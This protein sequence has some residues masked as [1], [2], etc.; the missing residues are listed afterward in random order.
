[1]DARL[2]ELAGSPSGQP[3]ALGTLGSATRSI[4]GA[5]STADLRAV[6][7][8]VALGRSRKRRRRRHR[9]RTA[10]LLGAPTPRR[11]T[12]DA[13]V[14]ARWDRAPPGA[15]PRIRSPADGTHRRASIRPGARA[16]RALPTSPSSRGGCPRTPRGHW[17]T[18]T[19]RS[20]LWIAE[21]RWWRRV[22]QDAWRLVRR[23]AG[24]APVVTGTAALLAVDAHRIAAALATA[25][26]G[27][28]DAAL[29]MFDA[30]A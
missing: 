18:S 3:F 17:R 13:S 6:P 11:C 5:S 15:R 24:G 2:A 28:A 21:W 4:A 14:G 16:S 1:M 8:S 19:R 9:P 27:G 12:R 26:H 20:E 30:S 10:T 22:E 7:G 23:G 29:E 25:A